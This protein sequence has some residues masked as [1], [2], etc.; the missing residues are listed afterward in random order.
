MFFALVANDRARFDKMLSWTQDNLAGGDLTRR[1]PAWSWG[2]AADG[3]WKILDQNPA[4]DA[5]LWMAYALLEAGR[6]WHEPRYEQLGTAMAS[7]I[8]QQEVV[9]VPRPGG[10]FAAGAAGISSRCRDLDSESELSAAFGAELSCDDVSAGAMGSGA[11]FAAADFDAGVG[12]RVCDG[13]G[14]GGGSVSPAA[15]TGRSARRRDKTGQAEGSYDA[16]RVYLWLG[17]AD[18][19][20]QGVKESLT[21]LHGMAAYM[22]HSG[23]A[24]GGG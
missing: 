6:L 22:K 19:E 3:S 13:L 21:G 8:A 16:I 20:T 9:L 24:P 14:D 7:H 18:P 23:T 2:K 15:L 4:S 11:G 17:I 10:D 1:L 5:D 12:R